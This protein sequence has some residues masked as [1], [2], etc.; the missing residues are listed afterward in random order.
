MTDS[1]ASPAPEFGYCRGPTPLFR[2]IFGTSVAAAL[3]A[4]VALVSSQSLA[5]ASDPTE[6]VDMFLMALKHQ[7]RNPALIRSG[8]ISYSERSIRALTP[9]AGRAESDARHIADLEQLIKNAP[10]D[11]ARETLKEELQEVRLAN[12]KS[13]G[14]SHNQ[15]EM[16][17][18]DTFI[19]NNLCHQLIQLLFINFNG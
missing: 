2:A 8:D 13:D 3:L 7:G 11:I 4:A 10:S 6:A 17:R 16:I 1:H 19:G 12:K 5:E 15:T 9:D 18:R 14:K